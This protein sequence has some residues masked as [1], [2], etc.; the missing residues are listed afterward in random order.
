MST[1]DFLALFVWLVTLVTAGNLG[2][3]AGLSQGL[4]E[5]KAK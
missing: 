2:Y 4:R 5:R 1:L 3:Q